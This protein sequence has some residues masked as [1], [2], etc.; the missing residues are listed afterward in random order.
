MRNKAM[1]HSG[2]ALAVIAAVAMAG[3]PAQ[4]EVTTKFKH[5]AEFEDKAA[6]QKFKIRGRLQLDA[7]FVDYDDFG[8]DTFYNTEV[9]RAR[10]GV[11]GQ[12]GKIKY[13]F[14]ASFTDDGTDNITFEDALVE[15][16]AGEASVIIGNFKTPNG[17]NELTSSR[18]INSMERTMFAEAFGLGRRLGVA[19][20]T[21][22][23][24]YGF[25]VGLFGD[26]TGNS[27]PGSVDEAWAAAARLYFL[28]INQK[29]QKL[30]VGGSL[31]YRDQGDASGLRYRARPN[32]RPD[33]FI[34]TG[35]LSADS[36]QFYGGEVAYVAGPFHIA[37]EYA[38]AV[39]DGGGDPDFQGGYI[40]G[41]FFL[42][43]ETR[44]YK[45]G[46][47]D[48]TKP[49]NS[50]NKG[51]SGAWEVR[52]RLDYL[53]LSDDAGGSSRGETTSY[54]VGLNWYAT[55][56]LRFMGEYVYA[57]IDRSAGTDGNVSAIQF[58][59]AIDW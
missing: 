10:L 11:E 40:E 1:L 27:N 57:D 29:N 43:G 31:R 16:N 35:T 52:G 56:Y 5:G 30:H 7:R 48:R 23:E 20:A 41:G 51:G 36:D 34:D 58:R 8:G 55:D 13:K 37:G 9:R 54:T 17:L 4:A 50:I 53:D 46:A 12:D 42:T 21:G 25:M 18:H 47:F 45:E 6:K 3:V 28:P 22:S 14:E 15:Y 44:G 32:I 33:R 59:T 49:A 38:Y 26:E 2:A 24:N 39:A 19:V